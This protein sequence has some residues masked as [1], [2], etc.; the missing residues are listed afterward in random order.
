VRGSVITHCL[1]AAKKE[2]AMGDKGKKDKNKSQKQKDKKHQDKAKT[3]TE[4]QQKPGP[5]GN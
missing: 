3:N 4:K 1:L 5:F 2:H